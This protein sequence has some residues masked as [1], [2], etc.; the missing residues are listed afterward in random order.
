[1]VCTGQHTAALSSW[2]HLDDPCHPKQWL[3]NPFVS[4]NMSFLI[5]V[6][7]HEVAS[8]L[9]DPMDCSTPGSSA[10]YC[11]P[12]FVSIASVMLGNISSSAP[13]FSVSFSLYPTDE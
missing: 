3:L 1:M 12:E 9:F 13:C 2:N 7:S 5:C 11:L 6:F 10:L 4:L 8:D